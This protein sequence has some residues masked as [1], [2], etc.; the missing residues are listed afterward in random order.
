MIKNN[1]MS[2]LPTVCALDC[3]DACSLHITVD[4][5]RVVHLAGNPSHPITRGFACA[6]MS[7]YPQRQEQSDR[8]LEP[9]KRIGSKGEGRFATV[10]WEEALDGI[11]A[12]TKDLIQQYGGQ[13]I[14]PYA[15]GGTMGVF[16]SQGPFAFFRCMGA[17]ELDQTICASTGGTAWEFNYGP[18]KLGTDPEDVVHSKFILL[19]GINALRSNSH[20]APVINAARKQ[21]CRVLHID[22]YR[23]ETSRFADMHWQIKVG[24][25]AALALAMGN[26]IIQ[27]GWHDADYLSQYAIGFEEYRKACSAWTLERAADYCGLPLEAL[28]QVTEQFA[29]SDAPFIKVGYGL[30]R[31]EGGGNAMRAIA[32][33]PALLGAWKK[34]GGGACLSTSGA[35]GLN[36][37]RVRGEHLL[38]PDSRHVNMNCLATELDPESSTIRGLFVFNSNPAAVAPDSARIRKGLCR[39]DLFTVV[40]E[41]FQTDTADF[42]DYLLPATTFLEHTDVYTSYGHYHLQYSDPVVSARGL[43]RS[44]RWVFA[45]LAK[46]LGYEDECLYWQPEEMLKDLL[47]SPNPWLRGITP[48]RLMQER[49]VKLNLPSPFLPYSEGSNYADR[50]IRFSP[51]PEQIEFEVQP[52]DVYPLRLISPPGP[53]ILNTSMGNVPSVIQLAGGQPQVVMHPLDAKQQGIQDGDHVE[54]SSPHGSIVRKVVVSEDAR[55]GVLVALG[56]WWPKLAPD[57]RGLNEI[58]SERLTDLGGGSTFGNPAVR[59]AKVSSPR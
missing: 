31:N 7:K 36:T 43:A 42:A 30:T 32:L 21:G 9:Q 6:K 14:L 11:A 39:E 48:Q 53:F 44:N 3:P 24:T 57:G 2:V 51:A 5:N 38:R 33:L 47:S 1:N 35:F 26:E 13:C 25:D 27:Q 59:V 4:G 22:P 8:L 52:D 46:R 12:K 16:E 55:Q 56:Q 41:H 29:T 45:E 49:S 34:R 40:L 28:Q 10:S 17:L 23:N 54:V 50:K 15:Y 58:T 37:T 18:N 20:L 19:W